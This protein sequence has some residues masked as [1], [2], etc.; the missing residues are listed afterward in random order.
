MLWAIFFLAELLGSTPQ[1]HD[2]AICY[3]HYIVTFSPF[4]LFSF[5]LGGLARI[6]GCPKLAMFALA[7]GSVSNMV[8]D[9]VFMYPLNMGIS[10]AALATAIGPVFSVAILLPHFLM[11]K[12]IFIL[13]S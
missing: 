9:Y 12:E 4:L 13:Q 6:D 7:F 3:L 2:K 5:L 10:G 8:L 1:I 11:K